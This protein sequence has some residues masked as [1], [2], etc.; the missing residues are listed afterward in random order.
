MI[1]LDFNFPNGLLALLTCAIIMVSFGIRELLKQNN[2]QD[3]KEV[4]K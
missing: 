4:G 1:T 3:K 2:T